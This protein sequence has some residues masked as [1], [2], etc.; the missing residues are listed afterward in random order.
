MF[1]FSAG[2]DVVILSR[3]LSIY[4]GVTYNEILTEK[5]KFRSFYSSVQNPSIKHWIPEAGIRVMFTD[6]LYAELNL[7]F[8]TNEF[9]DLM[10]ND[11]K[12]ISLLRVS[13]E[14]FLK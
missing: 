6:N 5:D 10:G 14:N 7:L 12:V 8:P 13:V 4:G 3:N 9:R 1:N 2:V 11:D